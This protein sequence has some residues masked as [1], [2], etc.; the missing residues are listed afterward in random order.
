MWVFLLS[1]SKLYRDK[2]IHSLMPM[3]DSARAACV[4]RAFLHS[5]RQHPYLILTKE[6]LGLEQN[7]H[8][9]GD[10]WAFTSKID[11]ILKNHSYTGV[12]R[13]ALDIFDSHSLRDQKGDQR[14]VNGNRLKFFLN[15]EI[16]LNIPSMHPTLTS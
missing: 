3:E 13:L 2:Y 7:A 10:A 4:S 12:K 14:G 6:T 11:Q 8:G 9:K 16:R 1:G 15:S 5:W